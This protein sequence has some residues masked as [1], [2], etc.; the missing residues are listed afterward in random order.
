MSL[1][2]IYV[3][4]NQI[5][6]YELSDLFSKKNYKC[7]DI[8]LYMSRFYDNSL[9]MSII[10]FIIKSM[11]K[12]NFSPQSISINLCLSNIDLDKYCNYPNLFSVLINFINDHCT[13]I[14]NK[15]IEKLNWN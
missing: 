8:T 5:K 9:T 6:S 1:S 4:V 14:Y 7:E 2:N 12:N 10:N 13:L 15:E 3:D 11:D